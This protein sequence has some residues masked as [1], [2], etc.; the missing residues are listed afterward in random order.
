MF[1]KIL[2]AIDGSEMSHDV[3]KTALDIAKADKANLLLL[4]VLSFEEQNT[5][6]T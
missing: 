2:T 5:L 3:F 1:K 4:H 6:S